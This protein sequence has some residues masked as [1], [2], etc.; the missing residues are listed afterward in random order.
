M[1]F[2]PSGITYN[3]DLTIHI[4]GPPTWLGLFSRPRTWIFI[5]VCVGVLALITNLW[6]I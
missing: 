3:G 5:T 6:R 4:G 2:L 1:N